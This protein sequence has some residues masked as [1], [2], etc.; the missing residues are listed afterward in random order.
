MDPD[1][2]PSSFSA[3]QLY[4]PESEDWM[5][6][7]TSCGPLRGGLRFTLFLYQVYLA[8]GLASVLQVRVTELPST[9]S[10]GLTD[11]L[12]SFGASGG[13]THKTSIKDQ[14]YRQFTT[15]YYFI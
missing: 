12:R 11:T 1:V 13:E 10:E 15:D 6:L 14:I 3:V 5:E 8:A 2:L 7:K 4:C 9:V